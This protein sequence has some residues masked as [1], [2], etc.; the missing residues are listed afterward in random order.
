MATLNLKLILKD[1]LSKEFSFNNDNFL[2]EY[3][4]E[5][6]R[7]TLVKKDPFILQ[8][9]IETGD[10]EN[11]KIIEN[12]IF[13]IYSYIQDGIDEIQININR[14]NNPEGNVSYNFKKNEFE[15]FS[16]KYIDNNINNQYIISFN[17]LP[18]ASNEDEVNNNG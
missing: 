2:F 8:A 16:I 17:I 14:L 12:F 6:E 4:L 7:I 5:S 1:Q 15:N 13:E 18:Q 9:K 10:S 11:I 3:G